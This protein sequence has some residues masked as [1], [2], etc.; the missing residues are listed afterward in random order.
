MELLH[1]HNAII[2]RE[3]ALHSGF[4]VKT[5]GDAF[6]L[7]FRSARD[8]LRCAI[9]VQ[10]TL[11]RRN[12]SAE[13]PIRVRIGLHS[14][15]L[16]REAYDFYGRHVRFASRVGSEA[17]AGEIPVS[18]LLRELVGHSGE[19]TFT[20]RRTRRLKGFGGIHAQYSVQW[21]PPHT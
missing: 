12:L 3:K 13:L 17:G 21:E 8:A 5:I 19:F 6:M 2:R 15:E 18:D 9:G 10:R 11:A 14:G 20:A 16:V 1:E 7:A 4:E